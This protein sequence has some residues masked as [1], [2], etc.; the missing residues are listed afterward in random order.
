MKQRKS[1]LLLIGIAVIGLIVLSICFSALWHFLTQTIF[2]YHMNLQ[3]GHGRGGLQPRGSGF[4]GHDF[5]SLLVNIGIITLGWWIWKKANGETVKKWVG[6]ILLLIGLWAILPKIIA[7]PLVLI[8]LY[9]TF[10]GSKSK[11]TIFEEQV[12]ATYPIYNTA[13]HNI[14]DEWERKNN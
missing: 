6:I 14:L 5:L 2:H 13:S 9:I 11:E 7:I 8:A 4:I 10:R 12:N 1:P 3:L